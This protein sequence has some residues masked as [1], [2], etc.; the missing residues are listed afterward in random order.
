MAGGGM[1]LVSRRQLVGV[2][3]YAAAL[4]CTARHVTLIESRVPDA[5][6]G[7]GQRWARGEGVDV[8][9]SSPRLCRMQTVWRVSATSRSAPT[10]LRI[11]DERAVAVQRGPGGR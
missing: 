8:G 2:H 1:G 4:R 5:E 11:G 9:A 7:R 6:R 10:V 3:T